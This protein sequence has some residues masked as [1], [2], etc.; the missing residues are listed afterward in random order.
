MIL[1]IFFKQFLFHLKQYLNKDF[2]HTMTKSK[3]LSHHGRSVPS[4]TNKTE[5]PQKIKT[6]TLPR[7]LMVR[8]VVGVGGGVAGGGGVGTA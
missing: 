3:H 4:K 8:I 7:F 5:L 2:K 6:L 1:R